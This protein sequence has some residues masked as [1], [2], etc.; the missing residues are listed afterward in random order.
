MHSLFIK[1]T[2]FETRNE[3][4]AEGIIQLKDDYMHR[5]EEMKYSKMAS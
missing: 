5:Y 3:S 4:Q 2:F 1:H